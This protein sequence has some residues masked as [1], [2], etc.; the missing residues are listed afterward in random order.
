MDAL[1]EIGIVGKREEKIEFFFNGPLTVVAY[2][3]EP[4]CEEPVKDH[5]QATESDRKICNQQLKVLWQNTYKKIY[6]I[7]LLCHD[8]PSDI[9][10]HKATSLLY[11]CIVTEGHRIFKNKH[12]HFLIEKKPMTEFGRVTEESLIKKGT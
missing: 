12:P 4:G 5:T 1:L 7:G 10:D 9:F 6:E 11:L 2:P 8:K 3:P